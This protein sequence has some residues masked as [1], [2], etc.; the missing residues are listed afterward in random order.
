MDTSSVSEWGL[1]PPRDR[2]SGEGGRVKDDGRGRMGLHQISIPRKLVRIQSLLQVAC[3]TSIAVGGERR[4][5][6]LEFVRA[7][8]KYV[9]EEIVLHVCKLD[10]DV[11]WDTIKSIS[12][13]FRGKCKSPL[14]RALRDCKDSQ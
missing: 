7:R 9:G 4:F 1:D 3:G 14:T 11:A 5:D 2:A 8:Q 10:I 6:I 13:H 12:S